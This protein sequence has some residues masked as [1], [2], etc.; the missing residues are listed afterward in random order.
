MSEGQSGVK[1]ATQFRPNTWAY[2]LAV[3]WVFFMVAAVGRGVLAIAWPG[4]PRMW[5]VL[6]IVAFFAMAPLLLESFVRR[7]SVDD[8]GLTVRTALGRALH[9]PWEKV[10][11][12]QPRDWLGRPTN[13][14]ALVCTL[15]LSERPELLTALWFNMIAPQLH[16]HLWLTIDGAELLELIESHVERAKGK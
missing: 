5:G 14:R 3:W 16:I 2:V 7:Y 9:I 6:S 15:G 10:L 1:G 8:V 11:R 12:V 13:A 4:V